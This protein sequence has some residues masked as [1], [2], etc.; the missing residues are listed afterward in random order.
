MRKFKIGVVG[1]GAIA[2]AMHIPGYVAAKNCV[3]TAVAD[4]EK[5]CLA[6]V[7]AKGWKF[8]HVYSDYRKML[9]EVGP[10]LDAVSVCTPNYLHK[11]IAVACLNAGCDLLLEKPVAITEADAKAIKAA[12]V[13]NRRRIMVSFTHRF[14][15]LNGAA[16][17]ALKAG[18]IGKPYMARVRF[19][20]TGPFPGWAKT[21]W[22]YN[23]RKAGGGAMLDMAI[24]AFDL[25]HFYL[26]PAAAVQGKAATLRKKIAVDDNAVALLEFG[27]KCLAYVE[28][29]WT[30]PAGFLGVELM[31][32]N[33]AI[34]VDYGSSKTTMIHGVQKPSGEIRQQTTV[35]AQ[36]Y[37]ESPN[38]AEM[39]HFT[40]QLAK[41]GPF[42][43]GI[44]D[45][46][47]ALGVALGAYKSSKTGRRVTL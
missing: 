28:V 7:A 40:T 6:E 27:P 4:P 21:D 43:V 26:G 24:H 20:H 29:G 31:G 36:G 19:A 39:R 22:F 1:A 15:E 47:A 9:R 41:R 2:Q 46:I 11:E 18:K 10:E 3:L 44:D 37:K 33:G 32:D 8:E 34:F 14:N 12:A 13:R 38:D 45:G 23:P 5:R 30:S 16:R 17:A 42:C 35:L 25:L